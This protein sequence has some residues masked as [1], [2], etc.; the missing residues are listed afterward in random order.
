MIE[1]WQALT[2]AEAGVTLLDCDHKT[3]EAVDVGWPYVGI[4]QMKSG[5][6]DFSTARQISHDDL[7][8]WTRKTKYQ[9]DD[10]ILSRRTN[11]GVTAV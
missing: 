1:G 11:P 2:L 10:V 3:P 9:Q 5:R 7:I 8:T 6:I 4:P